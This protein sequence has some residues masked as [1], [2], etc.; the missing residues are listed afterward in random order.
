MGM[1]M[2]TALFGEDCTEDQDIAALL[3]AQTMVDISNIARWTGYQVPP[4]D[5]V[6]EDNV[7]R[8]MAYQQLK[9]DEPVSELQAM[10]AEES[11][12]MARAI[13][14]VRNMKKG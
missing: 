4:H 9:V 1:V 8:L 14:E 6:L 2:A 3:L 10:A 11:A 5:K 7:E 13:E 12:K